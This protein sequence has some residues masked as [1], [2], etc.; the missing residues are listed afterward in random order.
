MPALDSACFQVFVNEFVQ[1]NRESMNVLVIDG[2]PAHIA[3]SLVIPDNVVLF[4]LPPYCPELNSVERVWQDLRNRLLLGLPAGLKA[5]KDDV[6]RVV[7]EYTPEILASI[8]GYSY[9]RR[10]SAQLI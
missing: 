1:A 4:R 6:A 7:C 5:L 8:T 10:A 3:H 2:A 9:L